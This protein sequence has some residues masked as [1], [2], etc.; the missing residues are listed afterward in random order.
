MM[1]LLVTAGLLAGLTVVAGCGKSEVREITGAISLDNAPVQSGTLVLRPANGKEKAVVAKI[2]NGK[3]KVECPLGT[4]KV[5]IT[6][7]RE[8]AKPDGL[9]GKV[10]QQ[11]IPVKYNQKSTLEIK[12]DATGTTTFDFPLKSK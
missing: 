2:E 1:R 5:D 9:G 3:Y 6:A 11:Y 10:Q 4:H 12:V 7:Q 8:T